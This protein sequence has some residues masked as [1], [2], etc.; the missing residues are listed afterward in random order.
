MVPL[1]SGILITILIVIPHWLP[2]L[3]FDKE[4]LRPERRRRRSLRGPKIERA[5]ARSTGSSSAQSW[6]RIRRLA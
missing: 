2:R 5:D 1:Q 3:V 4:A 6:S